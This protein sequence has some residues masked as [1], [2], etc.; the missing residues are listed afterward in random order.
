MDINQPPLH[1]NED[2]R[3]AAVAMLDLSIAS[4][5]ERFARIVRLAAQI[6]GTSIALISIIDR[7]TQWFHACIGIDQSHIERQLSFCAYTLLH[8]AAL[9][10]P[11]MNKDPQ[12]AQHPLVVNAPHIRS[13]AGI[14]VR[15]VDGLPVGTICV[16]DY[17]ARVFT[18]DDLRAL[19]DLAA[20][21][22]R[23]L[24][25]HALRSALAAQQRAERELHDART[26]LRAVIAAAPIAIVA[27][28]RDA[29]LMLVEGSNLALFGAQAANLVGQPLVT[30]FPDLPQIGQAVQH[31]LAG[32]IQQLIVQH[33]AFFYDLYVA[34]LR[35]EQGISGGAIGV[36][37]DITAAEHA[38]IETDRDRALYQIVLETISDA[39]VTLDEHGQIVYANP[40]VEHIFG[41]SRAEIMG[42]DITMLIP[43]AMRAA[44]TDAFQRFNRTGNRR[45]GSWQNLA[46]LGLHQDGHSF[47]IEVSF[48]VTIHKEQ[49]FFSGI[50]RDVSERKQHEEWIALQ[51]RMLNEVREVVIATNGSGAVTFW[52]AAAEALYGI[53]AADA[54][55]RSIQQLIVHHPDE[56]NHW[57]E[58]RRS[59]QEQGYFH[60]VSRILD[61]AGLIR[62]TELSVTLIGDP[63]DPATTQAIALVRD[64]T[65]RHR[66]EQELQRSEARLRT[67]LD[68]LPDTIMRLNADGSYLD[69]RR[70]S[71]P[72]SADRHPLI[73]QNITAVLPE[74]IA[75]RSLAIIAQALTSGTP[76]VYE[77]Q[78]PRLHGTTD[79]EA[80]V[81]PM[82]ETEVLVIVRD[83][84]E[85]KRIDRLKD[86]FIAT[87]SHELRTPLTS[88]RG[89][90]GLIA[91]GVA[92][93]LAPQV[94][95]MVDVAHRNSERLLTLINEI[96][97][98]AKI[99]SG[100]MV[101]TS[102]A[103]QLLPLLDQAADINAA[104]VAQ[105]AVT[106]RV[107]RGS[108]DGLVSVDSERILQVLTNLVSNA[109]KFSPPGASVE[110]RIVRLGTILRTSVTDHGTG[111]PEAFQP[112]IFQKFAQA[113]SS[114]TRRH[115][116]TGLGL[117]IARAIV[118]R[119]GGE[120]GFTT[121]SGVGT[122]FYFD[123]PEI[124]SET[125]R[126]QVHHYA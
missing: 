52:N 8:D 79:F 117:S 43:L 75:R 32:D 88:I 107:E 47:P 81:I 56:S 23:E 125:T 41:Y 7:T 5:E 54:Y 57:N 94:R 83:I 40:G 17:H 26:Q 35:D 96:L 103:Q 105:F 98:M 27:V 86:D 16:M 55:G 90:L 2:A 101:L 46:L 39:V 97:D 108:T 19:T 30:V 20:I 58:L 63:A 102:V 12:F 61:A 70:P 36:V 118:E 72:S 3:L 22:E 18:D 93:D 60:G 74:P 65:E 119:H 13:Y 114:N 100:T 29:R 51:A 106:V 82:T 99:E 21:V 85:R 121:T 122:T 91:G 24:S 49:R 6:F 80:R 59:I 48:G 53:S 68:A 113:D 44:H 37:L 64:V 120:I 71:S 73:G 14:A 87:V 1:P 11:D 110:L 112:H 78:L 115:G 25:D 38:R 67:L 84:T 33:G 15:S 76:Q 10:I 123:L 4:Y 95:A 34:P 109:A 77:Y 89:A 124:Y 42:R 45:L 50:I 9:V 111:I 31:A 62:L 66:S 28:D 126:Q 69:Y 116:G 104:Y 92:G